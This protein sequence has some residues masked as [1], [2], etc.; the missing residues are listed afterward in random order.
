MTPG[1]MLTEKGGG[2]SKV[3]TCLVGQ[4]ISKDQILCT[5][6]TVK[7]CKDDVTKIHTQ[8]H[9]HIYIINMTIL[10]IINY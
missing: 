4:D 10:S 5:V 6:Y 1:V 8:K 9:F 2:Q 7:L 3:I